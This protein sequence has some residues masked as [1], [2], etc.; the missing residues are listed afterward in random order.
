MQD[1]TSKDPGMYL[2]VWITLFLKM[3]TYYII[4]SLYI[5]IMYI[6]IY[7]F[8]QKKYEYKETNCDKSIDKLYSS[9]SHLVFI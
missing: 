4:I 9:C 2:M 7:M 1:A 8:Q 5:Y 3:D 6:Y